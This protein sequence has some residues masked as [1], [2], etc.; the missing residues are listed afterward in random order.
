LYWSSEETL[1]AASVC[2]PPRAFRNP[3]PQLKGDDRR[4]ENFSARRDRLLET[5]AN[6]GGIAVD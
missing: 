3:V 4:D 6:S 2:F 5:A 1:N